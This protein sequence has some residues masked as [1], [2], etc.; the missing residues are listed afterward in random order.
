MLDY[1]YPVVRRALAPAALAGW[2]TLLL[3][4]LAAG[5]LFRRERLPAFA[6]LFFLLALSVE[7]SFI[8]LQDVI[9]EHRLYLPM[10]GFALFLAAGLFRLAGRRAVLAAALLGLLLCFNSGLAVARNR[11]W[12]TELS[13]WS[14][15]VAKAPN[16]ARPWLFLGIAHLNLGQADRAVEY[17]DRAIELDPSHYYAY[18]NRGLAYNRLERYDLAL[19]DFERTLELKPNF[20]DA[21]FNRGVTR[22]KQGNLEAAISDWKKTVAVNPNHFYAWNNLAVALMLRRDYRGA[23][24]AVEGVRRAGGP[25]NPQ[26]IRA[27]KETAGSPSAPKPD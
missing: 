2:A 16:K 9:F 23:W 15:N 14:D 10:A 3:M 27:L 7:S 4:L 18:C 21:Y 8:P 25:V 17:L 20:A 11:V 5:G 12:R 26:L 22:Q 19:A 13:L 24:Q 6:I 1:D